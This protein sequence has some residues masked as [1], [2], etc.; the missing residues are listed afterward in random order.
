[1][2]L[3]FFC[4]GG[5]IG[6]DTFSNNIPRLRCDYIYIFYDVLDYIRFNNDLIY[7]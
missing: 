7:F 1:M 2:N 6:W 4:K 5:L 3:E